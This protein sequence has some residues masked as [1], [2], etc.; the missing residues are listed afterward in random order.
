MIT[1]VVRRVVPLCAL[2]LT[3]WFCIERQRLQVP[4]ADGWFH[5]RIGDE[6]LSDW[7]IADPGHLGVYDT[8][9][10]VPTQWASQ[11]AMASARNLGGLDA[12]VW[13]VGV[14]QLVLIVVIY[15]GCRTTTA[16]LPAA[17][18][19]RGGAAW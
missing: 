2:A 1:F 14:I 5:L 19:C 12:V 10:W 3:L 6:F 16:P 7:S 11:M 9:E 4:E 18:W 17:P 8:A 13:M 15:L